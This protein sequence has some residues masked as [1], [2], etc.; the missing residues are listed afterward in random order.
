MDKAQRKDLARAYRQRTTAAGI[1]MLTCSTTGEAWVGATKNLDAAKTS[2]FFQLRSGV[3]AI[4]D[5][6][7]AFKAHG[8]SAFAFETLE[9]ISP[10]NP[11]I[12]APLLKEREAHWR[13]RKRARKLY[14]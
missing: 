11:Q 4:K 2:L 12:V 3:Y 13:E 14:G 1:V 5:I 8:E 7:A 9:T 6:Q 10:E